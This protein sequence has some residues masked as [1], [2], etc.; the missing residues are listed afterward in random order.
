MRRRS[1]KQVRNIDVAPTVMKIL[2]VAPAPTADGK[3]I[4]RLLDRHEHEHGE[5]D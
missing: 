1:L 4:T 3:A 2:G 5:E